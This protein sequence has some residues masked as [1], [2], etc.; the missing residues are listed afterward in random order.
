MIGKETGKGVTSTG[1][2]GRQRVCKEGNDGGSASFQFIIGDF[3]VCKRRRRAKRGEEDSS[4][5]FKRDPSRRMHPTGRVSRI[6]FYSIGAKG[7][8]K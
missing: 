7:T 6:Q 4:N 1:L 3:E 5:E 2:S 8:G